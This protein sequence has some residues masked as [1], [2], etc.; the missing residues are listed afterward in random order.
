MGL[1]GLF[2]GVV[3]ESEPI[4]RRRGEGIWENDKKTPTFNLVAIKSDDILIKLKNGENANVPT[5]YFWKREKNQS[6]IYFW[7]HGYN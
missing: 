7:L 4:R 6:S 2:P 3:G 1:L 5:L